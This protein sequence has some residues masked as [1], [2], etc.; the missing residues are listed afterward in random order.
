MSA[1]KIGLLILILGLGSALETAWAVRSHVDMG[2]EG[3]RVLGGRFY[4]P[5]YS[6]EETSSRRRQ[7]APARGGERLR[8]RAGAWPA[9][10]GR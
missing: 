3:C 1:R 4:G 9:S 6:F 2:P 8:P 10:R 7:R 5:S